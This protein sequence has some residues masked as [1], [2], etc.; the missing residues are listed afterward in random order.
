MS[1][2]IRPAGVPAGTA[3]YHASAASKLT[4]SASHRC[5][6][7][8]ITESASLADEAP[9]ASIACRSAMTATA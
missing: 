7:L 1:A 3:P 6:S 5:V 2:T 4:D 8:W 9:T